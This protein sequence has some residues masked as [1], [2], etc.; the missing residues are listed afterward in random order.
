[1]CIELVDTDE[2]QC[3]SY[4]AVRKENY[5][6]LYRVTFSYTLSGQAS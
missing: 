2:I 6:D 5:G 4:Q 1:M 3:K